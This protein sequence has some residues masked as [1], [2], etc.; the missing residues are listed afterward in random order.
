MT[1]QRFLLLHTPLLGPYSLRPLAGELTR[2]GHLAEAPAWPKLSSVAGAYYPTLAGSLAATIDGAGAAD[3]PVVLA[4]HSGAGALVPA[5]AAQLRTPVAGVVFIDAVLPHPA[6][7]WFDTAP[8]EMREQL[9]GGAQMGQLPPWDDWWPPGAL[10]RLVPDAA[11]RAAL[12]AELEPLPIGYFE[13][14]APAVELSAPAAY[15]QLSGSYD[16]EARLAGRQG[17]PIVRLPLNH[18]SPLTQPQAVAGALVS[19]AQRL[20]ETG[21]G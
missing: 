19:L 3:R 21:H 2:L 20:T 4:A 9:R 17:W 16:D 12:V 18:L 5:L 6:R 8:A 15:L 10:E 11:A 13:E 14:P 1:A 7:S